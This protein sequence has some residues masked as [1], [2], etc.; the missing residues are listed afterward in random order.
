MARAAGSRR[1]AVVAGLAGTIVLAAVLTLSAVGA[2]AGKPHRANPNYTDPLK[3]GL[4]K[5]ALKLIVGRPARVQPIRPGFLGLSIEY[6]SIEPYAG[7]DPNVV[8]PVL[9][10][11]I[12]NIAPNQSPV[13]RIGGDS[14]DWT[15]WPVPHMRKPGGVRYTLT[16]RWLAVTK[17]LTQELNARLILGLDLEANSQALARTEASSLIDGIGRD[18]IQALEPGNEPELY[19]SWSWYLAPDGH[20]VKGR[21]RSWNINAFERQLAGVNRTLHGIPLAG[22]ATGSAK[23]MGY[24]GQFLGAAPYLKLVTLHRYPLQLCYVPPSDPRYPTIAHLLAASA[25]RGLAAGVAGY[26]RLSHRHGMRVRIDELNT[27]SCGSKSSVTN[28]FASALWATDTLFAMASAGADGV[29]VH[30]YK[31]ASY[32]LFT[33]GQTR[34]QWHA[35]VEPE[36]YGLWLFAIAAPPGSRLLGTYGPATHAISTWATR[37]RDGRLRVTLIN[38]DLRHSRTIAIKAPGKATTATLIRLRAP[39]AASQTAV[40]LGGE[41]FGSRTTSGLPT[42]RERLESVTPVRGEYVVKV[43][44]ASAA[45][46]VG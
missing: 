42:G 24:L 5:N 35:L 28:T 13:L 31:D 2:S 22:P 12:R 6:P 3:A 38:D 4:P 18:S 36:Y 46:L 40:T 21:A 1:I 30:T 16:P 29:N 32:Q 9:V 37:A 17:A 45:V 23:W 34:R 8:N 33:F 26:I 11:L 39:T 43:P 7:T 25:S 14:T 20:G 19:G 10:Q 44:P 27:N 41:G 15:W